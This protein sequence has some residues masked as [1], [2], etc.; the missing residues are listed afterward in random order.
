MTMSQTQKNL[1][2]KSPI[3][4]SSAELL[5]SQPELLNIREHMLNEINII[6]ADS[7]WLLAFI[8]KQ[9]RFQD[10][11][12]DINRIAAEHLST[13]ITPLFNQNAQLDLKSMISS[14]RQYLYRPT[15]AII[16][17]GE[18]LLE[19]FDEA[20][21][22]EANAKLQNILASARRLLILIGDLFLL[23]KT[24]LNEPKPRQRPL[25][26]TVYEE[27]PRLQRRLRLLGFYVEV[28]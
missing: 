23:A 5:A 18:M 22:S 3:S 4:Q 10:I 28:P 21:Q 14:K 7:Q 1:T 27:P 13:L 16:G 9:A 11:L 12:A 17:Y 6:S 24:L 15:N 19:D 26:L 8:D 2:N 20:T 25:L